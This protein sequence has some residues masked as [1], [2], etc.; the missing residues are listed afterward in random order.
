[1]FRDIGTPALAAFSDATHSD[2]SISLG[3]LSRF[4]KP[5]VIGIPDA[6]IPPQLSDQIPGNRIQAFIDDMSR[7][8]WTALPFANV[9]ST[10]PIE[11]QSRAYLESRNEVDEFARR[12]IPALL[13]ALSDLLMVSTGHT[14]APAEMSEQLTRAIRS[15]IRA[16]LPYEPV[17]LPPALSVELLRQGPRI[18]HD[19][20]KRTLRGAIFATCC[21]LVCCLLEAHQN[22]AVGWVDADDAGMVRAHTYFTQL[23]FKPIG[24]RVEIKST[25]RR[26]IQNTTRET[27]ERVYERGVFIE[28]RAQVTQEMINAKA[29]PLD[30]SYAPLPDRVQTFC[31]SIPGR[32]RPFIRVWDGSL[33]HYSI[34]AREEKQTHWERLK[35]ETSTTQVTEWHRPQWSE[36]YEYDPIIEMGGFALVGWHGGDVTLLNKL[37]ALRRKLRMAV[38]DANRRLIRHGVSSVQSLAKRIS[39]INVRHRK[40]CARGRA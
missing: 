33:I 36:R 27:T 38:Q 40:D 24:H 2:V 23:R 20:F 39:S 3:R 5:S 13:D 26:T 28:Q 29:E 15:D 10:D 7:N 31:R 11:A 16:K 9:R 35:S 25:D 4:S 8:L 1:M 6:E 37:T 32:L 12:D 17:I 19:A 18:S 22:S 14:N 30:H 21:K 34:V